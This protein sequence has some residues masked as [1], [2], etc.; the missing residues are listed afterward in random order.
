M[1]D[2]M[3]HRGP[4]GDRPVDV[5]RSAC[6][7]LGHRRLSII[8]LSDAAA[9]PMVNAAGTRG[10]S[11]S[12][13]RSTTTPTSGASS[14]RSASTSGSTD[15]S[16]TEMLLHAYEEWGLDCVKRFY[17]MFAIGVYDARDP[18]RPVAAPDP[19]SRR[20]QAALLHARP[21]AASGCSRRRSARCSRIRTSRRKW[22]A[23]AFWHYLTFIVTPAPLTLFRGI[24]K[25]PAGHIVT[26]DHT[27]EATARA[28]LGLPARSPR[29]R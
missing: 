13:A 25:L 1:R 17:G 8:D 6:C 26:I 19:R 2:R 16:D 22:I 27:G 23:T 24:F 4:D 29:R 10:A 11:P 15:H 21:R 7:T 3:A 14:R 20:H 5:A 12:T 28:V 9:Q 18:G